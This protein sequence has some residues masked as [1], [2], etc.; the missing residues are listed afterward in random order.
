[1]I[2]MRGRMTCAALLAV[3][4]AAAG[5]SGAAKRKELEDDN[6]RLSSAVDELQRRNQQLEE[7]VKRYEAEDPIRAAY[8]KK[9]EEE[10]ALAREIEALLG[11]REG[12]RPIPGGWEIE[13]DL[14]FEPGRADIRKQGAE[15]LK[16]MAAK[17]Q[18]KGAYL[19]IVGHTDSDPI[20]VH[21]R[22]NPTRMNLELG[23]RRA[24]AVANELKKA[25]IEET[26][27]HAVSMGESSPI[28]PNDSKENKKKN[29]RVEIFVSKAPPE[30]ASAPPE[31]GA[32]APP[33]KKEPSK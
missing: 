18:E 15:T 19:R 17:F 21:V 16:S 30:G 20:K 22:E 11:R 2:R 13:G 28:A 7:R 27:M 3:G 4:L 8:I 33:S 14:L 6:R 12:V 26:R 32:E 24:V 25:G 31:A 1:M 29:R 23:A 9:L 10:A 5:C